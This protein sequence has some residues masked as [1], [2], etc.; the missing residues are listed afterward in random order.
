MKI[1]GLCIVSLLIFYQFYRI[2]TTIFL[3]PQFGIISVAWIMTFKLV[4]QFLILF[5]VL[6][7]PAW[8]N[9]KIPEIKLG[10]RRS[11]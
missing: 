10:W 1:N 5:P 3:L 6:G 2:I 7:K 11:E 4:F 9:F 8:P